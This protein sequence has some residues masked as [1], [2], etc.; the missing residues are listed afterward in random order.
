MDGI[1]DT[2]HFDFDKLSL[3]PPTAL[4]G[5][6]YFIKYLMNGSPLYIQSPQCK[7]KGGILKSGKRMHCDLMFTNENQDFIKWMEDLETFSCKTI[8]E[9]REKWF[10]TE[11]DLPDIENYFA[12]PLKIYK[13][14]KYY[15]ARTNI[16]LRLGKITLKIYNENEEDVDPDMIGE[17]THIITIMEIQGIK[18]SARS[19]QIEIELKQMMVVEPV[20]VFEKCILGSLGKGKA[21]SLL[22]DEEEKEKEKENENDNENEKHT[23]KEKK[24]EK[25]QSQKQDQKQ[26]PISSEDPVV[27]ILEKV[28]L[29]T[30]LE[31]NEKENTIVQDVSQSDTLQEYAIEFDLAKVEEEDTIQI[32]ERKEIYY[33]MYRDALE[34]AKLARNM[35]LTAYLEAKQIRQTYSLDID[36]D[37]ESENDYN[38]NNVVDNENVKKE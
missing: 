25:D 21:P 32:K 31:E 20:D 8:F 10:E 23:D 17:N 9:N 18:C 12:S 13:S 14:G 33:K 3:T 4:S 22:K 24:R 7:T 37:S 27:S 30:T 29:T 38:D 15:L 2:K 34:K 19:F 26:D 1:Y 11:M 36:S 6:N 16:S 35:A 28:G 5:G